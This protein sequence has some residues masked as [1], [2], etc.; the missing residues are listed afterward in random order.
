[1][2]ADQELALLKE[3]DARSSTETLPPSRLRPNWDRNIDL[4]VSLLML[5]FPSLLFVLAGK[6][7]AEH[8]FS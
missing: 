6:T 7:V 8:Q 2:A 4:A 3:K 1:M 5:V